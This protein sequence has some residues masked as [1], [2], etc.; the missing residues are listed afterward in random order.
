MGGEGSVVALHRQPKM[1]NNNIRDLQ[2][3][4]HD[5]GGVRGHNI[6]SSCYGNTFN[7]F[8]YFPPLHKFAFH[9]CLLTF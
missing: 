8:H 9:I 6:V 7:I 2:S 4:F 1:C 5:V 3:H